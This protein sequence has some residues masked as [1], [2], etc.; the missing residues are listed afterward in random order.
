MAK[1]FAFARQLERQ[2][3]RSEEQVALDELRG[4]EAAEKIKINQ[5]EK[6]IERMV[7]GGDQYLLTKRTAGQPKRNTGIF[8]MDGAMYTSVAKTLFF[9]ERPDSGD[10]NVIHSYY[11]KQNNL[12]STS[13]DKEDLKEYKDAARELRKRVKMDKGNQG[14][15]MKSKPTNEWW[16]P[17][18]KRMA[19]ELFLERLQKN[20]VESNDES[21]KKELSGHVKCLRRQLKSIFGTLTRSHLLYWYEKYL[22]KGWEG[23]ADG[24]SGNANSTIVPRDLQLAIH[25][26][27]L[28]LLGQKIEIN[29]PLLRPFIVQ[30]VKEYDK[31]KYA[32]LLRKRDDGRRFWAVST[33]WIKTQLRRMN[34]RYRKVTNEAGKLP[35][36]WEADLAAMLI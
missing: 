13:L 23:L 26:F 17:N 7:M 10:P 14:R 15:R 1:R 24:R 28:R 2:A 32:W 22:C 20:F 16:S 3:V 30:F 19:V 27:I 11:T 31:G 34:K 35:D 12:H 5:R 9:F 21:W 29:A 33:T 8:C 4:K 6:A 18:A 36:T 25:D